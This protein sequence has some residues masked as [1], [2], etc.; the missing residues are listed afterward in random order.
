MTKQ[1]KIAEPEDS[2]LADY[3]RTDHRKPI[4]DKWEFKQ[5]GKEKWY[6]A[7]VPGCNFTDLLNNGLIEDPFYRDNEKKLQWIEQ[8]SW[9]YR[10]SF[11]LSREE[12]RFL[13]MEL[14][15]E[16]L[17]TYAE[18]YLNGEKILQVN[19]M[20]TTW[21]K[22][23]K[24]LVKLGKNDL[25]ILF[26]SPIE[27]VRE[28]AK[29]VGFLYPAGND[30]STENLSVYTRKAPYHFGWDWGPRFVSSGIW[31]PVYLQFHNQ[32]KV[33]ELFFDYDLTNDKDANV[34]LS[35]NIDALHSCDISI[36]L[37]CENEPL[38]SIY[39][40]HSL[41]QG[42][43]FINIYF[44]IHNCKKWWTHALGD[45]FLYYFKIT[46]KD[47]SDHVITCYKK[48]G[49]RKIEVVNAPDD[50]GESFY[51]KLNGF[52]LFAKGANYIP[53]N[54][55]LSKVTEDHYLSI[56]DDIIAANMNMIRIWGGGI[57]ESDMFYD[58]AD[59][60][61]VLIWQD[62]M[63]ACTLY[64][65]NE[66]FV[67][68]VEIEATQNIKRLKDHA[69][70]ALWCGNNEVKVGLQH[71]GWQEMYNYTEDIQSK[72]LND[73][74]ELFEKLLPSLVA[75]YDEKRFYFPSS[76]ISNYE[77][78]IDFTK[79]DVHYW[80]VWHGEAPFSD[81]QKY[82]PR[83]MSEYG[84]QSFP[85]FKSVKKYTTKEDWDIESPVMRLHQRHPKGNQLIREYL[86]RDYHDPKNFE[87]LLY[88][89]QVIQG[90]GIKTAMEAHRR[91]KPYCMG[92]LYWQLNDCWPV[93][94]W[95]GIDHYGQWK[96]LHY[97]AKHA[98]QN[99]LVSLHIDNDDVEVFIISDNLWDEDGVLT[100]NVLS[101]QGENI[102]ESVKEIYIKANKSGMY[103]KFT[104]NEL[105][106]GK[107]V[108]D[109]VIVAKVLTINGKESENRIYLAPPKQLNLKKPDIQ[110]EITIMGNK[111][112]VKL[113]SNFLVKN[114]YM[115]FEDIPGNFS[116]NFFDLIPR[117]EK[118][119]TFP[120]K[121]GNNK[122]IPVLNMI[123]IIDT[124]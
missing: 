101:L 69:S 71:W 72:L 42:C 120:N 80:G 31:R 26:H 2:V 122:P 61:G 45:P 113:K 81:Y 17:D 67:D 100:L 98:F 39:P 73:Y 95:S 24:K 11:I 84:F 5:L 106:K 90:E 75:K 28:K 23:V 79:G 121:T 92:T 58:M 13:Q 65:G 91:A 49:F 96:A 34:C 85:I 83:F 47:E 8:E 46:I 21:K 15:F 16:G 114:L 7:S 22:E 57:Y 25:E 116:D 89:S 124:F 18:I 6:K 55:F 87:S 63:F 70:L 74:D 40:K 123:S 66:D 56:F 27:F 37:E 93:A 109:V 51:I 86:L 77:N 3:R 60:K 30:Q 108:E 94:S 112:V 107:P 48:I 36:T 35:I 44:S 38:N 62:F 41:S 10:T 52:P 105:L 9:Q 99:I 76:P 111:I 50:Y 88:L 32:I 1:S 12:L 19:N 104:A 33:E 43:N 14:V 53:Q 20:F 110:K 103:A 29:K 97:F 118:E 82:I 59:E 117:Q 4:T 102:F 119:I 64:P 115:W 54:S 68:S 78:D